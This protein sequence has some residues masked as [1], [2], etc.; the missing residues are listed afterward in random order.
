MGVKKDLPTTIRQMHGFGV[1]HRV[2]QVPAGLDREI[3]E[4]Q[5]IIARN[6]MTDVY[7]PKM[8]TAREIFENDA[9]KEVAK[10][11]LIAELR[12]SLAHLEATEAARKAKQRDRTAKVR[13][14]K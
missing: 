12:A 4:T 8:H 1:L 6:V 5:E 14:R 11:K 13:A 10:D 9:A 7:S 2:K 3:R